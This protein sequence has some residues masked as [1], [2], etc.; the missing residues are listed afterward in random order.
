[1]TEFG[2]RHLPRISY[3]GFFVWAELVY[4]LVIR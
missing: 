2:Y 3:I 1:M 4:V